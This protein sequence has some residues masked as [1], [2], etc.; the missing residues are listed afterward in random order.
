M[1]GQNGEYFNLT[2]GGMYS[3][4]WFVDAYQF[5]GGIDCPHLRVME[6]YAVS[7]TSE[8]FQQPDSVPS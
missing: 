6:L 4:H 3:N 1:C 7:E 5:V 2:A 8:R